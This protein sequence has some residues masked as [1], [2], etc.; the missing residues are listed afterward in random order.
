MMFIL[1]ALITLA[2][3]Q[4]LSCIDVCS[5]VHYT[6]NTFSIE[7]FVIDHYNELVLSI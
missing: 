5:E 6:N 1:F 7:L 2:T 4:Y 3:D